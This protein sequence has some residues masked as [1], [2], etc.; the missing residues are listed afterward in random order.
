V[1]NWSDDDL[2]ELR[3]EVRDMHT[4][5]RVLRRA[6]LKQRPDGSTVA[7]PARIGLLGWATVWSLTIGPILGA[8]LATR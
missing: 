7:R 1:P 4:E 3:Q 5:I 8:Y 6:L 2:D